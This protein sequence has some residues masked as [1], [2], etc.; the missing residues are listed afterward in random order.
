M[1]QP[2]TYPCL[3]VHPTADAVGG[4]PCANSATYFAIDNRAKYGHV[5]RFCWRALG[6]QSLY[7]E[8]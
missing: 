6:E 3:V 5:C 1:I 4:G 7:K 8:R 2:T